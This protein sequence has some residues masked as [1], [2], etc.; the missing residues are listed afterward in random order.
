ML[1]YSKR[2]ASIQVLTINDPGADK[3]RQLDDERAAMTTNYA[4]VAKSVSPTKKSVLK[5]SD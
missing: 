4:N 3:E 2:S 5:A 1:D